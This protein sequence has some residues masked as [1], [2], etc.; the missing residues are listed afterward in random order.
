MASIKDL[1]AGGPLPIRICSTGNK[2]LFEIIAI[3][4]NYC[5]GYFEGDPLNCPL[6][7]CLDET[8]WELYTPPPIRRKLPQTVGSCEE[9]P[10]YKFIG[11]GDLPHSCLRM[12]QDRDGKSIS[13]LFNVCPLPLDTKESDA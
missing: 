9:C 2:N 11:C 10:Y 3:K 13:A 5:I 4:Q 12:R 6:A 1:I 8:G 7:I